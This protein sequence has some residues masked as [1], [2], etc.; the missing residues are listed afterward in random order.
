MSYDCFFRLMTELF[1]SYLNRPSYLLRPNPSFTF[2]QWKLLQQQQWFRVWMKA[3]QH[4]R[5]SSSNSTLECSTR[6]ILTKEHRG[7]NGCRWRRSNWRLVQH[8][9]DKTLCKNGINLGC[10]ESSFTKKTGSNR[11]A[12]KNRKTNKK[13]GNQNILIFRLVFDLQLEGSASSRGLRGPWD[14][15]FTCLAF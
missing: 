15:I 5:R 4:F 11:F 13:L 6:L 1:E 8:P 3:E 14:K 12:K 10:T 2:P 9:T 7:R